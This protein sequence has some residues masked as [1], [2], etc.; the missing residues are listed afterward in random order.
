MAT[1]LDDELK[2]IYEFHLPIIKNAISAA[3]C[4]SKMVTLSAALMNACH[5]RFAIPVGKEMSY[6][7][8]C[9][10]PVKLKQTENSWKL[11]V[12]KYDTEHWYR[13]DGFRTYC[14]SLYFPDKEDAA[15]RLFKH[16]GWE[17]PEK[18]R[19]KK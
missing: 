6:Q 11:F 19:V 16:L 12:K 1:F 8:Y 3:D 2:E 5:S 4:R 9:E 14:Y 15:K 17:I 13:E 10:F 18:F 7:E